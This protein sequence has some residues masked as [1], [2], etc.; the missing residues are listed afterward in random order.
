MPAAS[1]LT[2][3]CVSRDSGVFTNPARTPKRGPQDW[4]RGGRA[5]SCVPIVAR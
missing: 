1:L 3:S 5:R 4:M 2:D